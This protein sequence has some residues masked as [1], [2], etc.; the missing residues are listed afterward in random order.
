MGNGEMVGVGFDFGMELSPLLAKFIPY[1]IMPPRMTPIMIA[2]D[3]SFLI[4]FR[5]R[6]AVCEEIC[7]FLFTICSISW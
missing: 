3:T 1:K 2:I 5:Q 7:N 6:I 4:V